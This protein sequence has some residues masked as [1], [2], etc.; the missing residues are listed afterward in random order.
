MPGTLFVVA[1]P[2][3][4]LDDISARAL[5]VLR[6][7]KVIAAEDT[8]RTAR[9]LA[10]Y[11]IPTQT[12]SLH[13]HNEGLKADVLLARLARGEDVALVSDAGTPVVSDPGAVLVR[14]AIAAGIGIEPIPGPSAVMAALAASG[15]PSDTFTFLGFPPTKPKERSRWF[16][17]LRAAERTI[18][19]FEAPHRVAATLGEL[20]Q[21][22][23]DRNIVVARELTKTHQ[24]LVRGPITQILRGLKQARG[25]FTIVV[26][27]GHIVESSPAETP[28]DSLILHEFGQITDSGRVGR[29]QAVAQLATRHGRRQKDIYSAIERAK[30]SVNRQ[31]HG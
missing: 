21:I 28:P 15:F 16:E 27:L 25:E 10:R 14:K 29:R 5:D 8:R 20:A 24:E 9:L 31:N 26:D 18:V 6:R 3:G 19:F 17:E 1:T 30:Q 4:N 2:I 11:A 13:A 7:V 22:I 23:G 12:T